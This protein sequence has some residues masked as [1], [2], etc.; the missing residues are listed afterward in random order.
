MT[1]WTLAYLYSLWAGRQFPVVMVLL[2]QTLGS[3]LMSGDF[4]YNFEYLLMA[5][6]ALMLVPEKEQKGGEEDAK[7]LVPHYRA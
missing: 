2:L 4:G 7:N 3:A 6:V 1:L 5:F